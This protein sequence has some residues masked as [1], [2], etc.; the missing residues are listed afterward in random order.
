MSDGD[1]SSGCPKDPVN[2]DPHSLRIGPRFVHSLS[3]L[4][5]TGP[6]DTQG[7]DALHSRHPVPPEN[8]WVQG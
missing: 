7:E 5:G 3:G 4:H 8:E 1:S 2:D 6:D